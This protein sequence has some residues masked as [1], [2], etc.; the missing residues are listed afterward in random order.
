MQ[1]TASGVRSAPASDADA[2]YAHAKDVGAE[3]MSEV[4]VALPRCHDPAT[5][6]LREV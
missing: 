3:I 5:P 1:L 6:D 2:M 4:A